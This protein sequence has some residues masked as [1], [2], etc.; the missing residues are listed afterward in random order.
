M[1]QFSPPAA[2]PQA[3]RAQAEHAQI[4][5][6]SWTALCEQIR[7]THPEALSEL[8]RRLQ[9]HRYR[10]VRELEFADAQ[11]TLH[12]CYLQILE[13]IQ[14]GSIREPECMEGYIAVVARRLIW[15]QIEARIQGRTCADEREFLSH[16]CSPLGPEET[17]LAAQRREILRQALDSLSVRQREVLVRFYIQEQS[18][19]QIMAEMDLTETQFRLLKSRAKA[20]FGQIGARRLARPVVKSVDAVQSKHNR[21]WLIPTVAGCRAVNALS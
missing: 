1:T 10:F 8:Y 16:P 18:K 21:S 11:D 15:H 20:R 3:S 2:L 5:G 12:E 14:R 9:S 17:L 7:A 13:K 19:E 4:P 6:F